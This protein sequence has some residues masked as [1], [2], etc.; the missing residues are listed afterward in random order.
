MATL[1]LSA[2]A[3]YAKGP[4][5]AIAQAG[6]VYFGSIIDRQLFPQSQPLTA[7][8][9]PSG[10]SYGS[11]IPRVYGN[12]RPGMANIIWGTPT[13]TK[14]KGKKPGKGGG[15][16]G[17]PDT[18]SW[19]FLVLV[20]ERL[21]QG[22]TIRRIW[23]QDVLLYDAEASTPT[24][25]TIRIRYGD[26]DQ[27]PDAYIA[28]HV[29]AHPELYDVPAVSADRGVLTVMFEE[30]DLSPWGNYPPQLTFETYKSGGVQ[31]RYI[32]SDLSSLVGLGD[33]DTDFSA[34][35]A[36][37]QGFYAQNR[38]PVRN[39]MEPLL[40]V[41]AT[42]LSDYDGRIWAVPRG[43]TNTVEVD[44][45]DLGARSDGGDPQSLYTITREP[46]LTLPKRLDFSYAS[47]TPVSSEEGSE[48]P[49]YETAT[50]IAIRHAK[51]QVSEAQTLQTTIT[52][53][54]D[55][56]RKVVERL[57]YT[58]WLERI[59]IDFALPPK[60]LRVVP[61]TVLTAP[62]GNRTYRLRVKR[63]DI[64]L[65]GELRI[66][67]VP[68]S[69]AVLTQ[70]AEGAGSGKPTGGETGGTDPIPSVFEAF[71]GIDL[72]DDDTLQPGFYVAAT[73]PTGWA[74]GT[75]Y[76]SSDGGT[77]WVRGDVI[78]NRSMIGTAV[79][80]LG[81]GVTAG[82]WESGASVTVDLDDRAEPETATREEVQ[83]GANL[84]L[85][86]DEVI[87]YSTVAPSS[88]NWEL[89]DIL[90]G[91]RGTPMTS[92]AI[93]DRAI[94]LHG[95]DLARV[96]VREELIG[97]TVLVKVVSAGQTLADV[98]EVSVVIAANSPVYES[99]A[100]AASDWTKHFMLMGV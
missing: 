70:A 1:V 84:M 87:G 88:G 37:V 91:L 16:S 33:E 40:T 12:A 99:A 100:A 14:H 92:H 35:T 64:G 75:V 23:G 82:A 34:A 79:D 29:A 95:S 49:M 55:D 56:A 11:V 51:D 61:G 52:M 53:T 15:S 81:D 74:G 71:S 41:F 39:T 9:K 43:S 38:E 5:G 8:A 58:I 44:S 65:F 59:S 19:S 90:R 78:T 77:S 4:W 48:R 89:S 10:S 97:E 31:L 93:G 36:V 63:N 45:E 54:D 47:F 42:D 50:Q 25:H 80:A 60:Y 68:D 86:G 98:T 20:C 26:V 30:L 62:I 32:L 2:V 57:L 85:V 18:Y 17:T 96:N 22:E 3:T 28:A 73:G 76:W 6:A 69:A 7:D 67:G 27:E 83:N 66:S 46:D 94:S 13:F 21:T 72:R 24:K